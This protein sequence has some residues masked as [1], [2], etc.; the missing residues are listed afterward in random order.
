MRPR[1]ALAAL[2]LLGTGSAAGAAIG[3]A[4]QKDPLREDRREQV[5]PAPGTIGGPPSPTPDAAR[6]ADLGARLAQLRLEGKPL[7]LALG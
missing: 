1:T 4:P 2:L 5:W 6:L 7:G 3:P